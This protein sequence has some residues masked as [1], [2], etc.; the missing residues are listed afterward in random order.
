MSQEHGV[1]YTEK[2]EPVLDKLAPKSKP[3]QLP[4]LIS[5]LKVICSAEKCSEMPSV[6]P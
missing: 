4:W 3:A 1:D 6:T 5:S 2:P